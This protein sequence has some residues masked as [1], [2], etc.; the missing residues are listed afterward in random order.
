[1][2]QAKSVRSEGKALILEGNRHAASNRACGLN[3]ID[4][5]AILA[6]DRRIALCEQVAQVDERFHVSRK[7][8]QGGNRL[9]DENIQE[10]I[11][12]PR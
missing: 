5:L 11:A 10:G 6:H 4:G 8:S 7:K 3:Q 9:P 12:L 1:M 2:K